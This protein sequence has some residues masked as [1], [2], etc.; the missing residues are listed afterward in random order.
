M[1]TEKRKFWCY[2][3]GQSS[4]TWCRGNVSGFTVFQV[5][6]F[7]LQLSVWF[8]LKRLTGW[9]FSLSLLHNK[10]KRAH[11]ES[12]QPTLLRV[13]NFSQRGLTS[14]HRWDE[15]QRQL[16]YL[17]SSRLRTRTN[18]ILFMHTYIH[19]CVW[20]YRQSGCV[21]MWNFS[22]FIVFHFGR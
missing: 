8:R 6:Y 5:V 3:L 12:L 22:S 16:N 14:L 10:H 15:L 13:F 2:R 17:V 18:R 7:Y 19:M 20:Q 1:G 4:S 11:I 21:Q 9:L